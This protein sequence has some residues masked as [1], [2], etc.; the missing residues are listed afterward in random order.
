MQDT[1]GAES[2][3]LRPK[4]IQGGLLKAVQN[5]KCQQ[6]QYFVFDHRDIEPSTYE[7]WSNGGNKELFSQPL[8]T[9]KNNICKI[10][11]IEVRYWPVDHS[12]LGS[13]AFAIKTDAGWIA[14]SGDLRLHGERANK[15]RDFMYEVAEL[16][17]VALIVEGTHPETEKPTFE[18]EVY[19]NVGDVIK[20]TEGLVIA[21][22]GPRNIERLKNFLKACKENNRRLG[23]LVKDAYL[24]EALSH[25]EL[26]IKNPFC[27]PLIVL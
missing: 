4:E 3:Y 24:L 11:D 14:Y 1:G 16:E 22:F 9:C 5:G 10:N 13:G 18:S 2:C 27:E 12:I 7:F 15:T 23:I 26:D 19:A 25:S 21:D 17:P 6:R 20:S 8:I